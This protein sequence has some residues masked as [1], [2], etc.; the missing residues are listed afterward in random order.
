MLSS[1]LD[2]L[3]EWHQEFYKRI[4]ATHSMI[5]FNGSLTHIPEKKW[6]QERCITLDK[7]YLLDI[8]KRKEEIEADFIAGEYRKKFYHHSPQ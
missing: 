3:I 1:R 5:N 4:G 2:A 6:Q 8:V 7:E